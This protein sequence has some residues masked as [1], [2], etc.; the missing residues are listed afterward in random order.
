MTSTGPNGNGTTRD[1]KGGRRRRRVR[2]AAR[3]STR[4][5][6]AIGRTEVVAAMAA[7]TKGSKAATAASCTR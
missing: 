7:K 6:D 1:P 4:P 3:G 2:D 5:L